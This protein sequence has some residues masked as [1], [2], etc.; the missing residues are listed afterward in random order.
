MMDI[1]AQMYRTRHLVDV[2]PT[3]T[4]SAHSGEFNF[5]QRDMNMGIYNQHSTATPVRSV[6]L[7]ARSFGRQPTRAATGYQNGLGGNTNVQ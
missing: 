1:K 4:L 2:L 5:M 7:P 3:R 6:Q